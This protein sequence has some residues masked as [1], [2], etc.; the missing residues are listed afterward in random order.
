MIWYTKKLE[1]IEEGQSYNAE[2]TGH[3][4]NPPNPLSN[5]IIEIILTLKAD[6]DGAI[7]AQKVMYSHNP[8][9]MKHE[10]PSEED[11]LNRYNSN[12]QKV[13]KR[14]SSAISSPNGINSIAGIDWFGHEKGGPSL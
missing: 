7:V 2:I 13:I 6:N 11:I 12:F 1:F 10:D 14:V 9:M 8:S 5:S 4:N 3:Y